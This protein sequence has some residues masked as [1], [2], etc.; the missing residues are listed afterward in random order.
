[1][2]HL[3]G[4]VHDRAPDVAIDHPARDRLGDEEGRT[5]VQRHHEIQIRD[6]H[7]REGRRAIGA[8]VV[9]QDVERAGRRDPR[10]RALE[11]GDI[12]RQRLGGPAIGA[13]RHGG[14]LDLVARA[15]GHH[16]MRTRGSERDS[17]AEADAAACTCHQ[18]PAP[19]QPHGG[20]PRQLHRS[21]AAVRPQ[22]RSRPPVRRRRKSG[23]PCI[24]F[25]SSACPPAPAGLVGL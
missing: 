9:H 10:P 2:A 16:H 6:G 18:R 23:R 1:M 7:L 4:D 13:D 12:H 25:A 17:R 20:R 22:G 8:R 19:V 11:L 24:M 5:H 15:R 14:R 21:H 3:G